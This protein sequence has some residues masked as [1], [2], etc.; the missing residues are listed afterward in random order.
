MRTD[1]RRN[2]SEEKSNQAST[3]GKQWVKSRNSKTGKGKFNSKTCSIKEKYVAAE[4]KSQE[5][6]KF[7]EEKRK[8]M[9]DE[10]IEVCEVRE[11]S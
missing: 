4:I 2:K 8:R 7:R 11:F 5:E 3:R 9:L 1:R 6:E 10:Q